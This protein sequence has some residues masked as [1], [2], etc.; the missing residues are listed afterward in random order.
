MC[1]T[2]YG[3]IKMSKLKKIIIGTVVSIVTL[4]GLIACGGPD[5]HKGFAEKSNFLAKRLDL[6]EDQKQK[7]E[8]LFTTIKAEIQGHKDEHPKQK[9]IALLAEPKLNQ[10]AALAMLEQRTNKI[11]E[12]APKVI[13]SIAEF[14]NSLNNEQRAQV[15]ELLAKGRPHGRHFSGRPF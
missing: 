15:Q 13:A 8:S 6:N 9:I 4:G 2:F 12:S 14:T 11:K 10:N 7:M 1:L 5:H 3:K